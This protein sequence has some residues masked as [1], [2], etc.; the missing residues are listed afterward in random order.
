MIYWLRAMSI[1][2]KFHKLVNTLDKENID[3]ALVVSE[4]NIRY[5]TG[6]DMAGSALI[7]SREG[8]G[9][10]LVPLLEYTRAVSENKIRDVEVKAY[11]RYE[12]PLDEPYLIKKKY[13]DAIASVIESIKPKRIACDY[14]MVVKSIGDELIKKLGGYEIVEF[15]EKITAMRMI[16]EDDEIEAITKAVRITESA[17][18]K[19]VDRVSPG[20]SELEYVGILEEELRRNGV[21]EFSFPIIAAIGA[22]AANPHA[23]PGMVKGVSGDLLLVDIGAK[24]HGYCSDITR[25]FAIGSPSSKAREIV[26]IVYEAQQAGL[27]AISPGRESSEPDRIARTILDRKGFSRY[28]THSLGHGLGISV[29]EKPRLAPEEKQTLKPGMVVTV[30]PGVYIPGV[31]GVRI[32]DTVLVT[33]RGRK[34]LSRFEK[35]LF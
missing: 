25:M 9:V 2:P 11:Y 17:L 5:F 27:D 22:N 24:W 23:K 14:N 26:E 3:A 28:F 33:K 12:L 15:S 8:W 6:A 31:I 32:E 1:K 21:S 34:V 7:A 13:L 19:L 10:L 35:L 16:K 4:E 18:R 20:V 30:E 29:H